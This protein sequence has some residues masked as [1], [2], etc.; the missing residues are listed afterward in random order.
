VQDAQARACACSRTAAARAGAEQRNQEQRERREISIHEDELETLNR[1]DRAATTGAVGSEKRDSSHHSLAA[2]APEA[3]PPVK[4]RDQCPFFTPGASNRS[5]FCNVPPLVSVSVDWKA[6]LNEAKQQCPVGLWSK[7]VAIARE[8]GV[9]GLK[10]DDAVWSFRVRATGKQVAPTV[11][12]YPGDK[13]WDCDC[14]SSFDACEHVAAAVTAMAQSAKLGLFKGP[15]ADVRV[16]YDFVRASDGTTLQRSLVCDGKKPLPI[17]RTLDEI[18]QTRR[19]KLNFTPT[20]SDLAVDRLLRHRSQR[21]LTADR[22]LSLLRAL[23]SAAEV[24]LEGEPVEVSTDPVLPVAR[25][26]DARA[27]AADVVVLIVEPGPE[28]GEFVAPG[29]A[30]CN[31]MLRPFGA[32]KRFGSSWEKLP[33]RRGFKE[34]ALGDLVAKIIPELEDHV[35]VDIDT[36]RLPEETTQ[37][38]DPWLHFHIDFKGGAIEVIPLLVYGEPPTAR[39][40]GRRL[41][42]LQGPVPIRREALE[43]ELMFRLR[44]DL[45]LVPGRRV[46]FT[47]K[48]AARFMTKLEKFRDGRPESAQKNFTRGGKRQTIQPTL[49]V[50]GD[51]FDVVFETSDGDKKKGVA[52]ADAVLS[53]WQDG[54]AMVPLRDGTFAA[55]PE[56]WLVEHGHLVRDLLAARKQNAGKVPKAAL[57]LL[58]ELCDAMDVTQ[59]SE[60]T[61]LRKVLGQLADAAETPVS[62]EHGRQFCPDLQ[63]ELRDYQVQGVAWLT[64]LRDAGLGAILADDM[65]LGKTLQAICVFR[66][67]TLVVCPRSV[68]H[69]WAQEL[70]RFRPSLSVSLYHGPRRALN[71]KADVTLTTYATLR[72]DINTFV[73]ADWDIIVFD[74]AQAIKNPGS[75]VARSAYR[76]NAGFKLCL[77]GTPIENR[78]DELWSQMHFANRGLLGGRRDF[79][80]TYEKP[81]L[82]G[83]EE[84]ALRLRQRIRPFI[85]RRLKSEV[86]TELPPRSEMTLFCELDDEERAIYDSVRM[87][88]RSEVAK[89]MAEG[90]NALAALEALLRLRQAACHPALLPN[91]EAASSAKME[92]LRNALEDAVADG[93]KALVFSQWTSLLDLVEP[94]LESANIAFNRLDGSTRDRASVVNT[95]QDP[96]GP[97]VMLLSLKAGGTGL[98]LTAADHV[99]LLD[100]WWNPAVEDQAAD[101]AHRIGQERPVMIY[102]LVA[103]DTVEERVFQLQQR[104]RRLAD[105]A[106][107]GGGVTAAAPITREEILD[108]LN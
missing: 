65:G 99:F 54:L 92:V 31:K 78:L 80:E 14:E 79:V 7:G 88:S 105:V 85:M 67:R 29:I 3:L 48:D 16:R 60:L 25:I 108:L 56:S 18:S 11:E 96:D 103:K 75:G 34:T 41:V 77:S 8:G 73:K 17:E 57:G 98:N 64:Q 43:Q 51:E 61:S 33:I 2:E 101:R 63:G 24:R 82:A 27:S 32:Q 97:P 91:R 28:G 38:V 21:T 5:A 71:E 4:R 47:S 87:A 30:H 84:P 22:A 53:A 6:L 58:G 46:E 39:I 13:D 106:L 66:G 37:E 90:G 1:H 12:L 104:K 72:N 102:R 95:F 76:L 55:L 89:K 26:I 83:E 81:L 40:D 68:I 44:D 52:T 69:N 49:K 107:S 35:E 10:H 23:T 42:H 100:P 36:D 70:E 19:E 20:H 9:S 74:E 93:H 50:K 45:N 59:P 62:A 86:A 15:K 94:H